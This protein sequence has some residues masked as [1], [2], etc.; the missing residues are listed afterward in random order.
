[1]TDE[2][3]PYQR[4]PGI[5]VGH[6]DTSKKFKELVAGIELE[7]LSVLDVGCNL[8]EMSRL[9]VACGAKSVRGIDERIDYIRDA[10][11][12]TAQIFSAPKLHQ[13]VGRTSFVVQDGYRVTGKY[14]LAIVSAAFHYFA[15]PRRLLAQLA[16]VAKVVRIDVWIADVEA[17]NEAALIQTPRGLLIP[18][19]PAYFELEL[20]TRWGSVENLGPALSP[21]DSTRI[22]YEL[23]DPLPVAAR[24]RLIY[25]GGGTGKS[26]RAR[27]LANLGWAHYQLDQA[28]LD[29]R[30]THMKEWWSIPWVEAAL[31]GEL[32]E[33]YRSFVA[34]R[35]E[36][37]ARN[38][39]GLDL[40]V[41]GYSAIDDELRA[42]VVAAML[43][44]FETV[45]RESPNLLYGDIE[46][47]RV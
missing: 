23:S 13:F 24:A 21:D 25:G 5:Q 12:L 37:F 15:D 11:R 8:G 17:V 3:N 16:R 26:T 42:A 38:N 27:E 7:G 33:N 36:R 19:C 46:E 6:I 14:D 20:A 45:E 44:A 4:I 9:A 28:F 31:R 32:A 34:G 40:V 22:V 35:V 29:W 1:M 39:Y 41:E 43:H 18:A 47:V 30:M 2:R 10:G